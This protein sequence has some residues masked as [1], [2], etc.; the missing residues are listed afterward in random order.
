MHAEW[1]GS[2]AKATANGKATAA[3]AGKKASRA[4]QASSKGT[5]PVPEQ[6]TQTQ[7]GILK[8]QGTLANKEGSVKPAQT[9]PSVQDTIPQGPDATLAA[10]QPA[11]A[12]ADPAAVQ[13]ADQH[14]A[15]DSSQGVPPRIT[16]QSR[17]EAG[18]PS[19][20]EGVLL[21]PAGRG[22]LV[23]PWGHA[24]LVLHRAKGKVSVALF[25]EL[26]GQ[27][28]AAYTWHGSSPLIA[29]YTV[30]VSNVIGTV[31]LRNLVG[32]LK[33]A[34]SPSVLVLQDC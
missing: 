10:A 34:N 11:A 6:Q 4:I 1:T 14:A 23:D 24:P 16:P 27:I 31:I 5:Q 20:A 25:S 13:Q 26:T 9:Q 32:W 18:G 29:M 7:S 17:T 12:P 28:P 15:A 2:E 33:D 19:A 21:Q 3:A 30:I 8:T 22:V